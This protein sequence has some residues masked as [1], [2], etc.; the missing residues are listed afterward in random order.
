MARKN[1]KSKK[2]VQ[3]QYILQLEQEQLKKQEIN[4][5]KREKK[6]EN[7]WINM[8]DDMDINESEPENAYGIKKKIKKTKKKIKSKKQDDQAKDKTNCRINVKR[9]KK[10][11]RKASKNPVRYSK[12]IEMM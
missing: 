11:D 9:Q 5:Q 8:L 10:R 12:D 7:E 4:K 2:K 1:N 3:H 6:K